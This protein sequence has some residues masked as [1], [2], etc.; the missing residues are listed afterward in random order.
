MDYTINLVGYTIVFIL[1]FW[2][3]GAIF[4]RSINEHDKEIIIVPRYLAMLLGSKTN[5]VIAV[6]M[7]FQFLWLV[8]GIFSF[9]IYVLQPPIF[10]RAEIFRSGQIVIF[11]IAALIARWFR[12]RSN[13]NS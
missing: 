9:L 10:Q 3:I 12:N 7:V 11:L 5:K 13:K 4:Q 6:W 2:G 8:L 1:F